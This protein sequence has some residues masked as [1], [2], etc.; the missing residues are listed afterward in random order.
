MGRQRTSGE[1]TLSTIM[2][3][4]EEQEEVAPVVAEVVEEEVLDDES[5]LKKALKIALVNNGLSRGIR[6][7]ARDLD[8]ANVVLCILA[9]NCNE[10]AYTKLIKALCTEQSIPLMEWPEN[11]ALGEYAGLCKIDAGGNARKVVSCSCVCIT[12]YGEQSE[13]LDFLLKDISK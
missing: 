9:K 3:V 8:K 11:A 7:C 4:E 2:D 13:A 1:P 6:E 10:P 5:A 12:D